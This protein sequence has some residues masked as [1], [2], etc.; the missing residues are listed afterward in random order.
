MRSGRALGG[1]ILARDAAEVGSWLAGWCVRR[2]MPTVLVW[3]L[4]VR[5]FFVGWSPLSSRLLPPILLLRFIAEADHEVM[6]LVA[7]VAAPVARAFLDGM[8]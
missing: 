6:R 5:P 1:G 4:R 7:Q 2:W 3:S 8:V